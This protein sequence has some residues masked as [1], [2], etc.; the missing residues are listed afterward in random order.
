MTRRAT[1]A[2]AT[3]LALVAHAATAQDAFLLDDI[4]ISAALEAQA[5][6]R[7]G[8]TVTVITAD[9]IEASGAARVIDVLATVPGVGILSRGPAGTLSALTIRGEGRTYVQVLIARIDVSAPSG[10]QVAYAFGQ[11]TTAETS[12]KR[13]K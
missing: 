10:P 4:V 2:G 11:P 1:L 7:T 12:P 5:T 13:E 3:A 9:Q 8:T 6:E